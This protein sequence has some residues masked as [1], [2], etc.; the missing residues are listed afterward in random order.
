MTRWFYSVLLL[1]ISVSTLALSHQGNTAPQTPS[2]PSPGQTITPVPFGEMNGDVV[3]NAS[4]VV[5]LGDARFLFCDN[6]ANDAL[7]ELDLTADGQKRGPLIKR[8]LQG[9]AAD[10]VDDME[11]MT[12]A[13]EKGRRF[14]F[15][16]T[17]LCAKKLKTGSHCG[18][19]PVGCCV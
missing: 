7:F 4:G 16:T 18:C 9:L 19:R 8:P 6:N 14:V 10:A 5:P 13:V 17:S 12:F 1:L 15:V 2:Q 11:A 3:Y